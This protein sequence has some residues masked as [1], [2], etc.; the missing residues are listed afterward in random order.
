M[1]ECLQGGGVIVVSADGERTGP[2]TARR[3]GGA[4]DGETTTW[5]DRPGSL[6]SMP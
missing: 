1:T 4:H 2:S 6:A 3:Q 5:A